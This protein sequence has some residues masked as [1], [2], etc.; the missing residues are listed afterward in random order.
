M[1][2]AI[3]F[4]GREWWDES[5]QAACFS[6]MVNGFQLTCAINGEALL[7]RFAYEGEALACFSQ[8][9]WEL[10]EDAEQ[11]IADEQADAQGWVWLSSAR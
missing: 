2:Q 3:Q 5:H 1:N 10:E 4:P 11:A 6:A 9:R 7:R 8:Y